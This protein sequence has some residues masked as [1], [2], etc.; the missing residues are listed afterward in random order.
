MTTAVSIINHGPYVVTV[1]KEGDAAIDLAPGSVT[2]MLTMWADCDIKIVEP[3][4][5]HKTIESLQASRN[6]AASDAEQ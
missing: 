6:D 1:Q 3:R 4:G 2:P 5:F